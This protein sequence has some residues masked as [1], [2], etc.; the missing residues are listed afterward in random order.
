MDWA[1]KHR[2][3]LERHRPELLTRLKETGQMQRHL[4]E[5][6]TQAE[7]R[8]SRILTEMETE[9]P[10]LRTD[11]LESAARKRQAMMEAEATV[12][13]EIVLQ[14]ADPETERAEQMGGYVG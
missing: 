3:H 8:Y 2:E 14:P 4:R 10:P 12:M 9:S 1:A 6:A 5:I 13:R 7:D 11:F